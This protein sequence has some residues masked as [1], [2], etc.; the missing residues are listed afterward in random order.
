MSAEPQLCARF[1]V[2]GKVQGVF[3]RASCARQ[4]TQ[5]GLVGW[6]RNLPDGRV[7]VLAGGPPAGLDELGRWLAE[8]PALAV[9]RN[10]ERHAE[11]RAAVSGLTDFRTG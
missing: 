7:E 4:A 11:D 8:G 10:V 6:A 3:F 5:L 9:V 1:F 2:A